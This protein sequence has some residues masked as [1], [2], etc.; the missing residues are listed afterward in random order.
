MA[1]RAPPAEVMLRMLLL[2]H[3]RDWIFFNLERE[4]R[5]NLLY[6][7]FTRIGAEKVTE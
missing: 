6:R 4:V 7:E 1:C 3:I 5:G 2:K